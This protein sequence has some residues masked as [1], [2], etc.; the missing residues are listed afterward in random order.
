MARVF[1]DQYPGES[2]D[3][4]AERNVTTTPL[5]R[6][7]FGQDIDSFVRCLHSQTFRYPYSVEK[8]VKIK[9]RTRTRYSLSFEW[10]GN[11]VDILPAFN[12]LSYYGSLSDVY[13]AMEQ[14]G[15][16]NAAQELSVSLAP[17]QENSLNIRSYSLELL[18][19]FVWRQS[20]AAYPG[21]K[22]LFQELMKLLERCDELEIAFD[23]NYDSDTYTRFGEQIDKFVSFLHDNTFGRDFSV[24]EV[25][26]CGSLGKGTAV[27]GRADI[28]LVVIING[29]NSVEDLKANRV[30]LLESLKQK[31]KNSLG[32]EPEN[33]KVNKYMYSLTY[34]WNGIEVDILPA[35]DILSACGSPSGIYE[36][37]K[38]WKN[39]R[40]LLSSSQ[41]LCRLF[42][43]E[44]QTISV[45][46]STGDENPGTDK[47]FRDVMTSLA[48]FEK[49]KVA[50]DKHYDT[51]SYTRFRK[52]PYI[53]DPA[54]PFMNTLH[55]RP[56]AS[57][58]VS[59]KA[60][61]VLETLKQQDE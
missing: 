44:L 51:S 54:N 60:W 38:K 31:L 32:I 6:T 13:D 56:K 16:R 27:R 61:K 40:M 29:L 57:H 49:I 20:G 41:H 8:V 45:W 46:R 37:M 26:K 53:L 3:H 11:D 36:A 22:Y 5:E 17:Y 30:Q 7:R 34:K 42:S 50:F 9:A 2:L 4:F 18:T 35:V 23:D 55:G 12:L 33:L 21:T 15:S 48:N 43:L 1:R 28:D 47:L 24:K 10:Q 19:I 25:R 39:P 14:F 58:L 59:T 52:P